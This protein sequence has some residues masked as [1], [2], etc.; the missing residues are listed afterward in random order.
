M[1]AWSDDGARIAFLQK[2]GR[3]SFR[4][5]TVAVTTAR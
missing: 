1:P 2:S 4:L 3:R 5:M